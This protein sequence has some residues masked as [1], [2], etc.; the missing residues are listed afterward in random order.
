MAERKFI[1]GCTEW[2]MFQDFYRFVQTYYLPEN[3]ETYWE[4]CIDEIDE[5]RKKYKTIPL[6]K[7]L[8]LG[9][10]N[11]AE[12]VLKGEKEKEWTCPSCGKFKNPH[13]KYC[14]HCGRKIEGR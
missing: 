1:K 2:L 13:M 11:Y 12:E 8:L 14:P 3:R 7:H 6:S 5:I 4:S 10:L 9:F